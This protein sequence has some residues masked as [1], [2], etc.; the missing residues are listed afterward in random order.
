MMSR[1]FAL[2]TLGLII[3]VAVLLCHYVMSTVRA[4]KTRIVRCTRVFQLDEGYISWV[5]TELKRLE[6]CILEILSHAP[7]GKIYFV[8][9]VR[10][11]PRE[12]AQVA[13][14]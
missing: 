6:G 8:P 5:T 10:Q 11:S 4:G 12:F 14:N 7:A 1:F 2:R 3:D 9:F 13:R